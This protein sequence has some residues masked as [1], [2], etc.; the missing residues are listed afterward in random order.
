MYFALI[1]GVPNFD[2]K[3][4]KLTCLKNYSLI[5]VDAHI[6]TDVHDKSSISLKKRRF[7]TSKTRRKSLKLRGF[8]LS[9]SGLNRN[10]VSSKTQSNSLSFIS[11]CQI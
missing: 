9:T 2:T 8:G 10:S 1:W 6:L 5:N 3:V 11:R 7:K 4:E